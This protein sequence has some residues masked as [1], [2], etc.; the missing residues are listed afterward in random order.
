[1]VAGIG[2]AANRVT[3]SD[4]FARPAGRPTS[5]PGQSAATHFQ[6]DRRGLFVGFDIT[7]PA[8]SRPVSHF[9]AGKINGRALVDSSA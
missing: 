9:Q 4:P 3:P 7:V 8:P 5:W 1:V 6:I 2:W